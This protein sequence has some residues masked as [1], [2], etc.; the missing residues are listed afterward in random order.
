M[1]LLV[2]AIIGCM[3][4][5]L[6]AV[7]LLTIAGS[8]CEG[9]TVFKRKKKK[10][11]EPVEETLARMELKLDTAMCDAVYARQ[12]VARLQNDI[13]ALKGEVRAKRIVKVK[14]PVKLSVGE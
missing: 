1:D 13:L 5:A 3:L 4:L 7:G 9:L 10:K 8:I 11:P 12:E 6:F 14:L 2:W